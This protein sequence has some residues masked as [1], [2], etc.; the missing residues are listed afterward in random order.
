MPAKRKKIVLTLEQKLTLIRRCEKGETT[1]ALAKQYH[2]GLQTVRD[3]IKQKAKILS[4]IQ[5]CDTYDGPTKR[6]SMKISMYGELDASMLS[7]YNETR[8]TGLP[9]TSSMCIEQAK[10]LYETIGFTGSFNASAGWFTRFKQRYGIVND[11]S[12]TSLKAGCANATE[13]FCNEFRHLMHI[14]GWLPDQI[15]NAD[16]TGVYWNAMPNRST[17][18]NMRSSTERITVLC[19]A[20]AS[21]SHKMRLAVVGKVKQP[22]PLGGLKSEHLPVD[23]YEA[24]GSWMTKEIF[25]DWFETK[26]IPEVKEFLAE[27]GLPQRAV[28]LVDAAPFHADETSLQ[29]D[30]GCMIAKFIPT[31]AANLVQ[32]MQQGIT[33]QLKWSY[34]MDLLKTVS[35]TSN[36]RTLLDAINGLAHSWS[37]ISVT[38]IFTAWSK[39]IP[40]LGQQYVTECVEENTALVYDKSAKDDDYDEIVEEDIPVIEQADMVEWLYVNDGMPD[41]TYGEVECN[42]LDENELIVTANSIVDQVEEA[43]VVKSEAELEEKAE[44][45]PEE[46]AEAEPEEEAEAEHEEDAEAEHE[47]E[48]EAEHEEEAEAELEEEAQETHGGDKRIQL[49]T[50]LT[51]VEALLQFVDQ[52][53]LTHNEKMMLKKIQ[54]DVRKL[55][56]SCKIKDASGKKD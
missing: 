15:Y 50:V 34:R 23:Y 53:G 43:A 12:T 13:D 48:A 10:N 5:H 45:E 25:Q 7:W 39:L 30:D 3:I 2:I 21:G 49:H 32:P 17:A 16:E 14:E 56:N 1:Q 20:N 54:T 24:K 52:R 28:L 19:C 41:E 33:S 8:A 11:Y 35:I 4:F 27:K 46:E 22:H 37:N 44:A 40:D 6:K 18:P 26:W 38:S 36:D 51:S 42:E 55:N 47:E 9:I 29:T 31:H